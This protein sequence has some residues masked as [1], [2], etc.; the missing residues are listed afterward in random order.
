MERGFDDWIDLFANPG[1]VAGAF[2]QRFLPGHGDE[3]GDENDFDEEAHFPGSE[4]AR[5]LPKVGWRGKPASTSWNT[6]RTGA[7]R[8]GGNAARGW[9]E[10]GNAKTNCGQMRGFGGYSGNGPIIRG[11]ERSVRVGNTL[12]AVRKQ[13]SGGCGDGFSVGASHAADCNL[14]VR[15][16]AK[17]FWAA[18]L[19]PAEG[20]GSE[21]DGR[22]AARDARTVA[23]G[24][25][26]ES[27]SKSA[28]DAAARLWARDGE[29]AAAAESIA[30]QA[31][32]GLA[33]HA[34]AQSELDAVP[35]RLDG[36]PPQQ[37]PVRPSQKYRHP[38]GGA[39][40]CDRER[41][42][43]HPDRSDFRHRGQGHRRF[44][45]QQRR[46]KRRERSGQRHGAVGSGRGLGGAA[47]S[48]RNYVSDCLANHGGVILK[49]V[50]QTCANVL[51]PSPC[52]SRI[53]TSELGETI[54][55]N[56]R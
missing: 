8:V 3:R 13:A 51:T 49:A 42:R 45:Q 43:S 23:G 5:R 35:Q 40:E 10:R 2:L 44:A 24:N 12:C 39:Q 38:A 55:S 26:L 56:S 54:S 1:D 52:P 33:G 36:I 16:C 20:R 11:R 7:A 28:A 27:P 9:R 14:C 41:K 34:G 29:L 15:G 32:G 18:W 50:P 22:P 53:P 30:N 4:G 25:M 37:Q 19:S 47:W 21:W 31:G 6:L 46:R 17:V 48:A